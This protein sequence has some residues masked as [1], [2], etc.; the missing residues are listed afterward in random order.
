M[1]GYARR[2]S[3]I[4]G[5]AAPSLEDVV[6]ELLWGDMALGGDVV[7]ESRMCWGRLGQRLSRR[8]KTPESEPGEFNMSC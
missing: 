4:Q 6:E 8:F 2:C 1:P 3:S 5:K 7:Q